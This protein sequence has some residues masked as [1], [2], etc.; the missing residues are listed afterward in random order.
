MSRDSI[1]VIIITM[2]LNTLISSFHLVTEI[3]LNDPVIYIIK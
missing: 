2:T 3:V 1:H